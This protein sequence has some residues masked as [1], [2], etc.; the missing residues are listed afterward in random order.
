MKTSFEMFC[1]KVVE[2]HQ[3]AMQEFSEFPFTLATQKNGRITL[4]PFL[5]TPSSPMDF[6]QVVIDKN[7]P[8]M[9]CLTSEM[10]FKAIPMDK[11]KEYEK[12][13]KFGN[14]KDDPV[15]TEGLV[16]MGK[17]MDGKE[18]YN[19]LFRIIRHGKEI[20]FEEN[21]EITDMKSNKLT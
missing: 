7:T 19:K 20:V 10:W 14:I 13:Y 9:Y 3:K 1:E 2:I 16:V 4:H 11:L 6:V 8:D 5:S 18:T 17:T 15:K 21:K 12:N